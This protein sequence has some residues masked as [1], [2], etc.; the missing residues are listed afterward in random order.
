MREFLKSLYNGQHDIDFLGRRRL[1]GMITLAVLVIAGGAVLIR[2]FNLSIEFEGGIVWEAQAAQGVTSEDVRTTVAEAGVEGARVQTV[3]SGGEEFFLVRGESGDITS[4]AAVSAA[5]AELNG[6]DVNDVT[7]EEVSPSWGDNVTKKARTAL[8]WFFLLIALYISVRFEW[9][10]SVG[11]LVAVAHDLL[12]TVG[13]YALFQFEVTPATVIAFL[14]IMG[15]SL[16]DTIVV[17]DRV[18]ENTKAMRSGRSESYASMVNRSL[19]QVVMRSINTTI[20]SLLPVVSMLVVGS[21]ILGSRTLEEFA[22]ALLVGMLA[23]S[24]SSL[25]VAAPVLV[26]IKERERAY[27]GA[28]EQDRLVADGYTEDPASLAE[29]V[30]NPV[31]TGQPPRPRKHRSG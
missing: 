31:R 29:A 5:L 26:V 17:F 30:V 23:G 25:F 27:R 1:I 11:A 24:Y 8:V 12:I 9:K 13:F 3:R 4:Q 21:F 28:A 14:T 15:Y 2:G 6:I 22:V 10:M 18:S 16:Y 20:T 7:R 19:N